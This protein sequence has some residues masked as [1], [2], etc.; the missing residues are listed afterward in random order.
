MVYQNS[1][2]LAHWASVHFILRINTLGVKITP[3]LKKFMIFYKTLQGSEYA[4]VNQG[5]EYGS[6]SVFAKVLNTPG[7]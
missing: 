4:R 2:P 5:S 6:G 1:S 7:F 3:V